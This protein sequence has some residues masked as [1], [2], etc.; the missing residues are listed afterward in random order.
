MLSLVV[1]NFVLQME[2]QLLVVKCVDQCVKDHIHKLLVKMLL[3]VSICVHGFLFSA[4]ISSMIHYPIATLG[5]VKTSL[6]F[7]TTTCTCV[8]V[9]IDW[10][11][12]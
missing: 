12:R 6:L 3:Q 8:A 1:G 9:R 11:S 5:S 2:A 7:L 10:A 4:K